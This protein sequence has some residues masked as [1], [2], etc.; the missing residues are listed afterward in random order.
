MALRYLA[1]AATLAAPIDPP[2]IDNQPF[3]AGHP[4]GAT[5]ERSIE[6]RLERARGLLGRLAAV[7]GRRTIANTLVPYDNLMRELDRAGSEA[8]LIQSVHPDSGLRETADRSQQRVSAFATD[9][10]LD[11]RVFD[12]ITALDVTQ[13]DPA[14]RHYLRRIL[15]DFR[16]AGVDKD[17]ATR[18][19]V[20]ELR[21]ELVLIGQDFDRNVREDVREIAVAGAAELEGLPADY[22]AAHPAGPDGKIHLTMEYPDVFP[23][24]T[25]ARSGE[26]RRR[27]RT[28]FDNRAYPANMAVLERMIARRD[29]LARLLGFTTWADYAVADKMVGSA[30]N[31]SAFIERVATASEAASNRDYQTLLKR[32]QQDEP[33]ATVVNRWETS[34]YRELV[35]RSDYDFDSQLV[36]PYFPYERV[37]QG[38]LDISS[39]LFGVTF[40]RMKDAPVWH[41]S[42]EGW[43]MLENGKLAGRF[44]LDMH[45]RPGKFSHAAHFRVRTGTTDGALPESALVCNFPGG[46]P[47]EPG[48]M[49]H[50]DVEVFLHEFGHLMHSL[51]ARQRWNGISGVR[52]EWDFVEAPSQMLEEW[53]WD[54]GLLAGFARH[55]QTDQPIPAD[56]VRQL[57]RAT[58][59][60]R[61]LDMRTQMAYA[62]ISLSLYDRPPAQVDTDSIVSAVLQ[63]YT[64]VPPMADTH[65]QTSFTHLNGYSAYYYTYMWSLVIAKDLF[66][67]FDRSNLLAREPARRYRSLVLERGGAAPAAVLVEDFLGRPFSFDAWR[68]WLESGS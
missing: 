66:S 57:E 62:R 3:W 64:P 65:M 7:T 32:K 25:Y 8:G 46:T 11:R 47:G 54:P 31:A 53:S 41:E 33:G 10:S 40:R 44:Y 13:A 24:L 19:R 37:K 1:L 34:Y 48:L 12:A 22:I 45:P 16:L 56:V 20:K 59:F 2:D 68:Q 6:A 39:R 61:A 49:D 17:S 55:Y 42:V 50:G 58:G 30:A 4:D 67:K 38:V 27:V 35:R 23:I 60:G 43:E 21:D 52:T 28:E 36:R 9:L 18:A 14:T 15:R 26:L 29:E 51:L 5:F 63:K